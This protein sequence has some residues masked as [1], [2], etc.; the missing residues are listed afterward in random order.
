L[1]VSA[2]HWIDP[3]KAVVLAAII[4]PAAIDNFHMSHLQN[5][6]NHRIS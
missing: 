4:L 5:S 2:D 3:L 6:Q 1:N